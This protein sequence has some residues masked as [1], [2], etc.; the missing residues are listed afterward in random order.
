MVAHLIAQEGPLT[1]L[2]FSFEDQNE[3]IIGRDPDSADFI[4]EDSTV[5]RKHAQF[6][7]KDEDIYVKNL[8]ST[9]PAT[10]NGLDIE[11]TQKLNEGDQLQIG[12][13]VFLFSEE[14]LP[15]LTPEP[16]ELPEKKEPTIYDSIFEDLAGEG[17]EPKDEP[18]EEEKE[19]PAAP[20]ARKKEPKP[21]KAYDTIFEDLEENSDE[22]D[23]PFHFLS[24]S[25][26]VLKV[27][28]GPNSG[29]EIGLEK[30]KTY[31]IGKDPNSCDIVFQDLSV[32]RNH[33]RLSIDEN[34]KC[35]IEDLGSKNKTLVN[36]F[37]IDATK[38]L[39]A[40]DLISLGT[41]TFVIIDRSA[42]EETIYSPLPGGAE[43]EPEEEMVAA[44]RKSWKQEKIP[45]KHLI[46][47]GSLLAILLIVFLSFFSLFKTHEV[48]IVHEGS[49]N[50]VEDVI[51]N[52][53]DVHYTYNPGSGKLFLLGH[54]STAVQHQ[55]LW[56][57][58]DQLAFLQEIE[59]NVI[60]DEYVWKS[61]NDVLS[62]NEQWRG[63]YIRSPVPG[64]FI[65]TGYVGTAEEF[66]HLQEYFAANFPYLDLLE[67]KVVIERVLQAQVES[68]LQKEGLDG[69]TLQLTGGDLVIGGRYPENK[70]RSYHYILKE[71]KNTH[72]ITSVQSFAIATTE[73][74]SRIDITQDYQVTGYSTHDKMNYSVVVN[75][76]ILAMG[77][78]IDGMEITKILPKMILLEKDGLKYKI[79]YSR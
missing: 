26:L 41:T 47:G 23:L 69:V 45:L 68:I 7:K 48:Q 39:Q 79:N 64:K 78:S 70:E 25:P 22:E 3:W 53:P 37:P 43:E 49:E 51:E 20:K 31:L 65:A 5:S 21:S 16:E 8:S 10:V 54:I 6:I 76:Q 67:N 73:E 61:M 57:Q 4:L 66:E 18:S 36:H 33:A 14:D 42:P 60:I 56:Y 34:G 55:E 9:N 44:E 17:S 24:D 19:A 29:A 46:F 27:I 30:G 40:Q 72:G 13:S 58:L 59:D 2:S 74:S 50:D 62:T 15:D 77:E 75:G 71:L 11:G 35:K 52:Y 28:S 12:H 32:S 63:V 1:G 38:D